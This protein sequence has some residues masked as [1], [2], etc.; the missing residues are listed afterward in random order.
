MTYDND[1]GPDLYELIGLDDAPWPVRQAFRWRTLVV[2]G[3][4]V[5]GGVL[6]AKGL[7][8]W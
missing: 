4:S 8:P 6:Y 2:V 3:L 7:L 5:L 1:K